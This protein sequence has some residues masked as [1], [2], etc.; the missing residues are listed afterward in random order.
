MLTYPSLIKKRMRALY[1][2]LNEKDRRLYAAV[3]ALK[4][5]HGGIGY[6]SQV[7][8]C[9]QKTI[10]KGMIELDSEEM[11]TEPQRKKGVDVNG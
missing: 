11:V 8:S 4:L 1:R 9:D 10:R 2:A 5:G 3:E 7:L 6:V